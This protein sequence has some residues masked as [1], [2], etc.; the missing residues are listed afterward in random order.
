MIPR[1]QKKDKGFTLTEL[2]V[3]IGI[4]SLLT[5][6]T[7]AQYNRGQKSFTLQRSAYKLSQDIR[8]VQEM[9]MS[10]KE[11]SG[12]VPPRYG[13]LLD[14]AS[15]D[16]YKLF[17]DINNNGTYQPPDEIIETV[18]FEKGIEINE[19][20][21]WDPPFSKT[22]V[23]ITFRPP[24]PSTEIRDPGGPRSIV[25]IQLTVDSQEKN[26]FVNKAGLIYVE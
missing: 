11:R 8:V 10:A 25:R 2:L 21:V 12:T 19:I 9:A 24:D 6:L 5:A 20:F 16:S 7:F 13:I 23:S 22:E 15:P 1:K 26:V 14:T 3:V 4:I 18:Y 17:S